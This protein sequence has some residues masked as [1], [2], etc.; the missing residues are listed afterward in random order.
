[1]P[2]KICQEC[3]GSGLRPACKRCEECGKKQHQHGCHCTH[4]FCVECNA[5]SRQAHEPT[6]CRTCRGPGVVNIDGTPIARVA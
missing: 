3:T 6:P 4:H 1:M 2:T 5:T